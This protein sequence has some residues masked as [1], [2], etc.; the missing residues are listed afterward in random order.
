MKKIKIALLAPYLTN[1]KVN[2]VEMQ[3]KKL[4][5][6]LSLRGDVEP[7]V[8][9]FGDENEEIKKGDLNIHVIK[10]IIKRLPSSLLIFQVLFLKRKIIEINPDIVHSLGSHM[11]YSTVAALVRNKYPTLLTVYGIG[12]IEIEFKKGIDFIFSRL[13]ALPHTKYV[14]SKVPNII[15]VSLHVKNLI[16]DVTKSRIYVIPNGIDFEDIRNVQPHKSTEYPYILYIGGLYKIKGIDILLNAV[17]KIREKISNP[18]I[19]IAGSGPEE[20]NLKKLVKELNIEESVK[21]LGFISEEDKFKFYLSS[22]I[23]VVPSRW[24]SLPTT[25]LEAMACGRSIIASNVGGILEVI[26]DGENGLLFESGNVEDLADKIIM[27]LKDEE[28]REE[29]GKAAKEKAKSYDWKKIAERTVEIYKEVI[30]DFHERN[31]KDK[32]RRRES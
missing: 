15:A 5:K 13:I 32:K 7:H 11:P 6:Y 26:E 25:L 12:S 23:A 20:G 17:P 22:K 3:I 4:T 27:L 2:G 31:A 19:Y 30:A 8:I 18:H 24:D 14:L 16:N 28:L 29:M 1:S 9:T 21:F 10:K